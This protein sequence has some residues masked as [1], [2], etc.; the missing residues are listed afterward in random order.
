MSLGPGSHKGWWPI[1]DWY[2]YYNYQY[3]I[4]QS[5]QAF[6]LKIIFNQSKTVIQYIY[7]NILVADSKVPSSALRPSFLAT[8]ATATEQVLSIIVEL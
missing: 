8:F 6:F 7:F 3:I 5:N 1:R 2:N 4:Q